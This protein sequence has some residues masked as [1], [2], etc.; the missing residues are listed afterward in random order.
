MATTVRRPFSVCTDT[1]VLDER[2][3]QHL[4]DENE[5]LIFNAGIVYALTRELALLIG[6]GMARHSSYAEYFDNENDPE[7]RI[8]ESGSYYV[9]FDPQPGWGV[10]FV[11]GAMLRAGNRLAFRFGY[12]TAPGGMSVGGYIVFP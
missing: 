5:W 10:Q 4:A 12:E 3:D 1:W 11:A 9:D 6:G 7:L 8:T 2:N